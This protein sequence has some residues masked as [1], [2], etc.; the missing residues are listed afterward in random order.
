MIY[1]AIKYFRFNFFYTCLN[2]LCQTVTGVDN[3]NYNNGKDTNKSGQTK[4]NNL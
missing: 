3:N 4:A 1:F 2:Y